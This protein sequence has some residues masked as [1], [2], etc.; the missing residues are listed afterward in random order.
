MAENMFD[1]SRTLAGEYLKSFPHLWDALDGL[2]DFICALGHTLGEEYV[3]QD[4]CVW[5]HRSASV[6]KSAH[7]A[8]PCII[9]AETEVRTG[10]YLRGGVLVGKNCVV[11]N[12]TEIKNAVLFDGVQVPHFN[13]VGDSILGYRAHMGAGAITSN[14]KADKSP[15]FI[16]LEGKRYDTGRKKLG[17]ILGDHVEIGC[18]CVLNPGTVVG[19][20]TSVYPLTMLRGEY[21]S[22][23]IVKSA[24]EVVKRM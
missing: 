2:K 8:P 3:E 14:V 16:T 7:I 23:S 21:P 20:N 4:K 10:A 18:N 17:A 24:E 12:S 19:K 13:Y 1:F 5:V 11:G 6:H 9:C 22:D 15:V